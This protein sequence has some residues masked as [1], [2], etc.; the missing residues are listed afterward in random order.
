MGQDHSRDVSVKYVEPVVNWVPMELDGV[1]R[2]VKRS[3]GSSVKELYI[4]SWRVAF[5]R[6]SSGI[7]LIDNCDNNYGGTFTRIDMESSALLHNALRKYREAKDAFVLTQGVL[8]KYTD[9][10][11]K[12]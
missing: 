12:M 7:E 11:L 1:I 5:F 3:D 2:V 6:G 8:S 10:F 9:G 4:P